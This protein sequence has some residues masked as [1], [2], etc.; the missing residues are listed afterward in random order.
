M[1]YK[2]FKSNNLVTF[3]FYIAAL[4]TRGN[5]FSSLS[6]KKFIVKLKN[7]RLRP[8]FL[9]LNRSMYCT[10]YLLVINTCFFI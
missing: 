3:L 1:A 7:Q 4:E 6:D 9:V 5:L 2:L 8:W 10:K